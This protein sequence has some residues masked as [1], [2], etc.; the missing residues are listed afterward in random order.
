VIGK[1]QIGNWLNTNN[2][3]QVMSLI[4]VLLLTN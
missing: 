1:R 4:L 2:E 3:D